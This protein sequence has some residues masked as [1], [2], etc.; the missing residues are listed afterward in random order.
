MTQ[1]PNSGHQQTRV[2]VAGRW[3]IRL[4][5]FALVVG[6]CSA[7]LF[8]LIGQ[9]Q[10][11]QFKSLPQ[12][13]G[14]K[15]D[16]NPLQRL[17][18]GIALASRTEELSQPIGSGNAEVL[19]DISFGETAEQIA[20]NLND[21]DLLNDTDL[22]LNYLRYYGL[23][24]FLEA[25]SF[26]IDPRIT[27]PELAE[28]LINPTIEDVE[29]R[30]IEGWRLEEMANY[31]EVVQPA[32]IDSDE[33]L[34][35]VKNKDLADL[36]S[37]EF[38]SSLPESAS[39]EG[40]LFPDTY[41]ISVKTNAED[42]VYIML[43]NFD[44]KLSPA[45]RQAI[46]A[47]GLTIFEAVTLASIIQRESVIAS[48]SP[49]IASVFLN[50]IRDGIKLQ[51]DPTVQYALGYQQASSSWWKSP[52][53]SEDLEINS[54]YN[55]YVVY[56]LPAGPISNPGLTYLEAIAAPLVSDYYFFVADCEAEVPGSHIFSKTYEEHL[57]YVERCR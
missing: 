53:S 17:Y 56:G 31:L 1:I 33:F 41:R 13:E 23:D 25:G 55:T 12:Y 51:A 29:L 54:P 5:A 57:F 2:N 10:A 26:H 24:S 49:A 9:W 19:F 16:L 38:L 18:L 4:A 11:A 48:E 39:L 30:F 37:Y 20:A 28:R 15:S 27:Y 36:S 21:A 45:T 6:L 35:I 22:F 43:D 32:E 34:R 42:L 14:I 7:A 40:F 3:I 47:Q 50:R 46:G 8:I 52:L 44:E